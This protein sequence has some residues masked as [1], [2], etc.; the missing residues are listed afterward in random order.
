MRKTLRVF[1][2]SDRNS[3]RSLSPCRSATSDFL[4]PWRISVNESDGVWIWPEKNRTQKRTH[5]LSIFTKTIYIY[6]YVYVIY[7]YMYSTHQ[8]P[9][10]FLSL[11]CLSPSHI[12][13]WPTLR[14]FPD[15]SEVQATY[16]QPPAPQLTC[17]RHP[18]LTKHL[19]QTQHRPLKQGGCHF[20]SSDLQEC[21]VFTTGSEVFD[22]H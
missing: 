1:L 14:V 4:E 6:T 17:S 5:K 9:L 2:S 20:F 10:S 22:L 18:E 13:S 12:N 3:Q 19:G 21:G 7:I 11:N 8:Y 15:K 16:S